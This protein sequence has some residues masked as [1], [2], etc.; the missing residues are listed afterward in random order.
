MSVL[1]HE[2]LTDQGIVEPR[3]PRPGGRTRRPPLHEYFSLLPPCGHDR[4]LH[5]LR[6]RRHGGDARSGWCSRSRR[7]GGLWRSLNQAQGLAY[8]DIELGQSILVVFQELASIFAAL[9]DALALVAI[10]GAGFL[11]DV[12]VRCQI[13]QVAFARNAFPV[14]NVELGFAE[15]CRNFV[16]HHF[17]PSARTSDHIAIFNGCD[18]PNIDADRRIEL[19]RFAASGR[20]GIA[21]HHTDFFANLVDKDQAGTRLGNGARQF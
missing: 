5:W 18:A 3:T 4:S 15:R 16:L 21:E 10:P 8:F 2:A 13:E 6:R 17:Y 9:A 20:L 14:E 7:R 11:D 1:A 19:E 12:V